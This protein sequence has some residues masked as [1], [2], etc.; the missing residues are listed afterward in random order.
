[1]TDKTHEN[2][3][4]RRPRRGENRLGAT[5]QG[6]AGHF[7]VSVDTVYRWLRQGWVVEHPDGSIDLAATAVKVDESRDL[8]GGKT[9][10]GIGLPNPYAE[11]TDSPD[12]PAAEPQ[13]SN[14]ETE[15]DGEPGE[16]VSLVE[17][18]R[19]KEV[20]LATKAELEVARLRGDLISLSEAEQAYL[21]L[22]VSARANLETIPARLSHRLVGLTDAAAIRDILAAE[23]E[24]ALRDLSNDRN[25]TD[26]R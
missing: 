4:K 23:I 7:G 13:P 21:D 11:S 9:D 14:V 26:T 12:E 10:R 25:A 15:T 22:I 18:R 17:A 2:A 19:R 1:V 20:A 24:T 5:R 16:P 3:P 8:R 6:A